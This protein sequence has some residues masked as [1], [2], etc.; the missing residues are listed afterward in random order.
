ESDF[1]PHV[2]I[3][4]LNRHSVEYVLIGDLAGAVHGSSGGRAIIEIS[5]RPTPANVQ[6]LKNALAELGAHN[7]LVDGQTFFTD[8]GAISCIGVPAGIASYDDLSARASTYDIGEEHAVRVA[9]L[10]DL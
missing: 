2:I 9:A 4:A 5:Y 8:H 10:D 6:S 1:R 3:D 7:E